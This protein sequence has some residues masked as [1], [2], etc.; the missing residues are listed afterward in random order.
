MPRQ[1]SKQFEVDEGEEVLIKF[2]DSDFILTLY[3]HDAKGQKTFVCFGDDC[4]LCDIGDSP[5]FYA[6]INVVD[7]RT[8]ELAL[9]YATPNPA[10]MIEAEMERLSL[11][12]KKIS[13][14]SFYY[15]ISKKK[16]RAGFVTY[17][18]RCEVAEKLRLFP[19]ATEPAD[20]Q[21]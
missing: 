6:L 10:D 18:M 5:K 1:A 14:P 15:A 4:P 13:D 8:S 3:L 19:G 16:R 21:S 17:S 20:S 11:Q 2:L 9:W 12:G 7:M